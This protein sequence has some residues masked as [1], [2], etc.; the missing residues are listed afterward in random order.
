MNTKNRF[1]PLWLALA[2]VIGIIIGT[3]YA[4]N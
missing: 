3:F 4:N 1:S 2:V